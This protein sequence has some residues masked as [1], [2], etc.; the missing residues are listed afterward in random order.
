MD[1]RKAILIFLGTVCVG[2]GV[3]GMFLPLMPTTVFLLMA[4][5]C[6]SHSSER[7]HNWLMTNKMFGKYISD[8]KSG[9]G[10]SLRQKI[11]TIA[12]LWAS[13]GISIWYVAGSFW[14]T[15]LLA[16]VAVGVTVHLLWL[17]TSKPERER[18]V[19][20]VDVNQIENI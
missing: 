9:K 10:I 1:V 17:K 5:Y 6:Y 16:A 8:Y 11:S 19:E 14:L 18:P 15:L 2:L 12:I 20:Q 4:A 7:F 3:M 13:I